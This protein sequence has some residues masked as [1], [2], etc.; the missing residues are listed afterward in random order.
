MS[1]IVVVAQSTLKPGIGINTTNFSGD[2]NGKFNAKVGWQIG[3]S[4]SMGK[5]FFWEP[6]IFYVSKSTEFKSDNTNISDYD[7]E[8]NGIRIP[9]TI[10]WNFL[11]RQESTFAFRVLGGVSAFFVTD[12]GDDIDKDLLNKTTWGVYAGV[13]FDIWI[14]FFD[15]SYE[16]GLT[17]VQD[18][19]SSGDDIGKAK[20]FLTS[21]GVR[22]RLK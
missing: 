6:G 22:F 13:G 11:G 7:A 10:G 8:I 17:D 19:V 21:V 3:A 20:S 4:F 5:N 15:F 2:A 18:D 16:W 14:L 12:T 1:A 9:V